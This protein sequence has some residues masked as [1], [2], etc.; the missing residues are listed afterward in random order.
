MIRL[1]VSGRVFKALLPI[2]HLVNLGKALHCLQLLDE[3]G[4]RFFGG[5]DVPIF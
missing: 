2:C 3:C 1:L 5:G 4:K